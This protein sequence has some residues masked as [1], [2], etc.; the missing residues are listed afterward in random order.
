MFKTRRLDKK[1]QQCEQL[2]KENKDIAVLV[3]WR[4]EPLK[5]ADGVEGLPPKVVLSQLE[6]VGILASDEELKVPPSDA[7]WGMLLFCWC[8]SILGTRRFMLISHAAHHVLGFCSVSLPGAFPAPYVHLQTPSF[9]FRSRGA[10]RGE[11]LAFRAAGEAPGGAR[12]RASDRPSEQ[13]S[14]R[15]SGQQIRSAATGACRCLKGALDLPTPRFGF[16]QTRESLTDLPL[17]REELEA[18]QQDTHS[19]G[20]VCGV[21]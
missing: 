20:A 8:Q 1:T 3:D 9:G 6:A 16:G 7:F 5:V 13:P 15:R 19:S 21:Q 17:V 11:G 4:L 2:V 12:E 10:G 18:L 14:N